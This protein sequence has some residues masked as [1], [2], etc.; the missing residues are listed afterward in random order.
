MRR[1]EQA[2]LGAE[3]VCTCVH[4]TSFLL[5][6]CYSRF[7]AFPC[8]L[9]TIAK[10]RGQEGGGRPEFHTSEIGG[11][12]LTSLCEEGQ[13]VHC[14]RTASPTGLAGR[15]EG[16]RGSLCSRLRTCATGA[17]HSLTSARGL[18]CT[19][20]LGDATNNPEQDSITARLT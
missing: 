20:H 18:L 11:V 16:W 17:A 12:S 14:S 8:P 13:R 15:E 9:G 4:A 1:G 5:S 7:T 10:A 6:G 19:C 3:H 2:G